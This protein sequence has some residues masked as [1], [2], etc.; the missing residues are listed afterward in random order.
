VF[1]LALAENKCANAQGHTQMLR[2]MFFGTLSLFCANNASSLSVS[3]GTRILLI[4]WILL[5]LARS[6]TRWALSSLIWCGFVALVVVF[7]RVLLLLV[8]LCLL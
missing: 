2:G 4:A 1:F 6:R 3:P 7:V 8:L 5:M